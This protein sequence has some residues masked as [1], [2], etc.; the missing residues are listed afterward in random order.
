MGKIHAISIMPFKYVWVESGCRWTLWKYYNGYERNK[1]QQQKQQLKHTHTHTHKNIVLRR[2]KNWRW[3]A[4]VYVS[5]FRAMFTLAFQ[6]GTA[7]WWVVFHSSSSRTGS[8]TYN[9]SL[10]IVLWMMNIFLHQIVLRQTIVFSISLFRSRS[11]L[12]TLKLCWFSAL[13]HLHIVY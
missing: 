8:K 11:S 7:C 2:K 9:N 13:R 5:I 4:F 3:C 12:W 1:K 10:F 6:S